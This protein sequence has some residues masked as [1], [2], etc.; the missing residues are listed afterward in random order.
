MNREEQRI[1]EDRV[2]AYNEMQSIVETAE[3]EQ[4][5]LTSDEEAAF[6]KAE[7]SLKVGNAA[8]ELNGEDSIDMQSRGFSA[9]QHNT[10]EDRAF[11]DYLRTGRESADLRMEE[12]AAGEDAGGGSGGYLV[13]QS[14]WNQ[15]AV[16]MKMYGGASQ[17]F[18]QNETPDGRLMP[19]PANNPT[20]VKASY[21]TENT[22]VNE[23]SYT[24]GQ[25]MQYA[26]TLA[27]L[28]KASL[29]LIQDS[30]V[31]VDQFVATRTGEAIG[32]Q[33]AQEVI[34]GTGASTKNMTGLIPS[35]S[36]F[37][38]SNS[39]GGYFTLGVATSVKTFN[40][41]SGATELVGNVLSPATVMKAVASVDPAYWPGS[42]WYMNATQ[43]LNQRSVVDANGRPLLNLDN[44]Y[45]DGAI[46]SMAGFPVRVVNEIPNLA[47]NTVGGPVFGNL[48]H[49][50]V[51]RTVQGGTLM[52]LDQRYADF[53]QMGF[54]AYQRVDSQPVDLRA[55]VTVAGA[56]T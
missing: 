24:F 10:A 48:S 29:Q 43:A 7:R 18:A 35:L 26:W 1:R 44:A 20:S 14:F 55:C 23:T 17:Y 15:L 45:A 42:A 56:A 38:S 32:R 2:T 16:A 21:V 52:R 50:M 11:S 36:A 46:G 40:A 53:L 3:R 27:I 47:A 31:N 37:G 33:I 39:S 9:P 12:R 6:N 51:L 28:V 8:L 30:A 13:P 34:S 4:R 41:P 5:D 19:F 54:L 25:G 49:A 22:Q